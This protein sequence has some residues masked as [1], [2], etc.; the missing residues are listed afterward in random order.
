MQ[1]P[2]HIAVIGGGA[3]GLTAAIFAANEAAVRN[4][5]VNITLYEAADRVGKKILVTGNGRCN[6]TNEQISS[7]SYFG[8]T[9]LFDRI[10]PLFDR[11][12][13]LSFFASLGL[14]T[15]SDEAGRI[16]PYSRK[17]ASVLDA[18]LT[19]CA[20]LGIRQ[21]V[22]TKISSIRKTPDGYL[23]NEDIF[24]DRAI[25]AVGGK[26]GS[27]KQHTDGVFSVLAA[28]GIGCAPFYPALT[29]F[30]IKGFTKS[31]KGIRA[32]GELMLSKNGKTLA[33]A[34]GEI[35]YTEYGISGIAAMELS[36]YAEP[37]AIRNGAY[38]LT[39]DSIPAFAFSELRAHFE[40]MKKSRPDMPAIVFLTG[41]TPKALAQ[42]FLKESETDP[43]TPL[44]DMTR[45]QADGLLG[46][47]KA[48]TY[49]VGAL[50]GFENAQ[51]MRGGIRASELTDTLQMKKM[52]GVYACGEM[53]DIIGTCGGYNL[54]WAWTS[55]AVAGMNCIREI[56]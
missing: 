33:C 38:A 36:C 40:K 5:K 29:A 1:H 18:L 34:A 54:Q 51:V 43:Q 30:E 22:D 42:Y 2:L 32:A 3:S 13:T 26:A 4:R 49:P 47:C 53:I 6:L 46:L 52:P 44:G 48:K 56:E 35:Q 7:A 15:V 28:A 10:Y 50:R 21:S 45:K 55:G 39:A 11:D 8:E 24:A 14:L 41:L 9:G 31:L 25:L 16:Y 12:K 19:E 17:A 20:R 37:E 23:L 27:A